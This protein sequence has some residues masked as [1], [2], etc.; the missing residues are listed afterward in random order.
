MKYVL[1]NHNNCKCNPTFIINLYN[2]I[3]KK[4]PFINEKFYKYLS[5]LN[6]IKNK[7]HLLHSNNLICCINFIFRFVLCII[8][9]TSTVLL[10]HIESINNNN[11]QCLLKENSE[12]ASRTHI[13]LIIQI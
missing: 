7:A 8:Q 10:T 13:K 3:K 1:I 11:N 5:I 9:F 6:L 4:I 2:N 12:V